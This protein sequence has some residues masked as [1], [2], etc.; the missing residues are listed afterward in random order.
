[1]RAA[2]W[3]DGGI[4]MPFKVTHCGAKKPAKRLPMGDFAA[5]CTQNRT[6]NHRMPGHQRKSFH[7]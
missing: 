5:T 4:K 2:T 6:L 7:G 1:M 3:F